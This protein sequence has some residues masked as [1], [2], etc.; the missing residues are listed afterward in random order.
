MAEKK[1]VLDERMIAIG[2]TFR[3]M[4]KD[5]GYSNYDMIAYDLDMSRN[6]ISRIERG[7][8]IT[9]STLLFMLDAHGMSLAEFFK[10]FTEKSEPLLDRVKVK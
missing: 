4:R 10:N 9:L 6:Q 2:D 5:A 1:E 8:N 7:E 3:K